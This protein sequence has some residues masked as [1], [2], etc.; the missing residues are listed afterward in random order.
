MLVNIINLLFITYT[1][2]L[3]VRIMG[4]WIPNLRQ[5][6]IIQFVYFYTEPYLKIFRKIIP[7]I[8]GVIDFS[9]LLG[10][11]ALKLLQSFLLNLF[12]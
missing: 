11:F 12:R 4:S 3:F 2:M 9:P 5:S 1:I 8:G 10:F 7:P 6:K